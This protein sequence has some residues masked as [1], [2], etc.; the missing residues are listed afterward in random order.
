MA[1]TGIKKPWQKTARVIRVIRMGFSDQCPLIG[2]RTDIAL[3]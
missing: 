3:G 2:G 1:A